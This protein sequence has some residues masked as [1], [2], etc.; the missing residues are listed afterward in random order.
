MDTAFMDAWAAGESLWPQLNETALLYAYAAVESERAPWCLFTCW[1][2]AFPAMDNWGHHAW[3][4]ES[5]RPRI[6]VQTLVAHYRG[7][8]GTRTRFE[9]WIFATSDVTRAFVESMQRR[10]RQELAFWSDGSSVYVL[11][12]A[13]ARCLGEFRPGA[14]AR[15]LSE[16]S[17][18]RANFLGFD[19]P[20]TTWIESL[21]RTAYIGAVKQ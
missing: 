4:C 2:P 8:P 3:I 15:A 16:S 17:T 13:T 7:A 9:P 21:A 5:L 18:E 14:V 1:Q 20:T 19:L 12:A 6:D 10:H 11:T